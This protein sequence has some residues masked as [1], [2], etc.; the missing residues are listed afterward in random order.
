LLPFSRKLSA[1]E[2][3]LNYTQ[4]EVTS[5]LRNTS[6][7]IAVS[8]TQECV[9]RDDDSVHFGTRFDKELQGMEPTENASAYNTIMPL[10][11]EL[12]AAHANTTDEALRAKH[13][14]LLQEMITATKAS[15]AARKPPPK[16]KV[17]S[18]CM[19]GTNK[20]KTQI[21]KLNR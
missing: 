14:T 8:M 15:S 17:V 10:A 11:K 4:E 20:K 1:E 5:A 16:G 3:V 21:T 9:L 6:S 7:S 18:V 13:E 19:P 2:S 12:I